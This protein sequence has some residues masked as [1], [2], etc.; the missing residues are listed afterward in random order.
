MRFC[1]AFFVLL[2]TL[3]GAVSAAQNL[4]ANDP[5]NPEKHR[6]IVLPIAN[7][8]GAY[9]SVKGVCILHVD[10][11]LT[12]DVTIN[13]VTQQNENDNELEWANRNEM[14]VNRT[15]SIEAKRYP[16]QS[17]WHH[18]GEIY[19]D[20]YFEISYDGNILHLLDSESGEHGEFPF[21]ITNDITTDATLGTVKQIIV[22]QY[23]GLDPKT[24]KEV[25]HIICGDISS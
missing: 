13:V 5:Q 15:I 12:N 1:N 17:G 7:S 9:A 2:V 14:G 19:H 4:D 22:R 25:G 24:S 21:S 23:D 11:Q 16:L 6:R 20:R 8:H 3:L 18:R 10:R